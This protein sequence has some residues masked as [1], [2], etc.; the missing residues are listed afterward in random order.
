M[1]Y[2]DKIKCDGI[3][4]FD[5]LLNEDSA[6]SEEDTKNAADLILNMLNWDINERY[7][8]EQCLNHPFIKEIQKENINQ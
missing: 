7:S 1:D 5:K 4:S 3:E 2:L 8:A 6:Y